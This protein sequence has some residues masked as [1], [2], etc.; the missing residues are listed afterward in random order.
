MIEAE[1]VARCAKRDDYE[2]ILLLNL[3]SVLRVI[4]SKD[5]NLKSTRTFYSYL[6]IYRVW[7]DANVIILER[8]I[9][10]FS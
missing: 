10:N 7:N 5:D 1:T 3:T 2:V 4:R 9:A 8:G 6:S